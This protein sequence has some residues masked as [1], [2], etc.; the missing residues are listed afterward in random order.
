M[1]N[2]I[3][4][5]KKSGFSLIEMMITL[6]ILA[7]ITM[8]SIPNQ[9]PVMKQKQVSTSLHDLM[10]SFS[11]ARTKAVTTQVP[12][13]ICAK[14]NTTSMQCTSSPDPDPEWQK[15]WLVFQDSN[16]NYRYDTNEILFQSHD[17]FDDNIGIFDANGLGNN[18]AFYNNGKADIDTMKTIVVCDQSGHSKAARGIALSVTGHGSTID[19]STTQKDNCLLA[20]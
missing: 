13:V 3:H 5:S 19:I 4:Y 1:N 10:K 14:P 20:S 8:I 6:S 12:V 9:T 7:I 2:M 17:G 16:N 18:L 15:G 11:Y